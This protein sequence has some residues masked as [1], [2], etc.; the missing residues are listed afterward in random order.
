MKKFS[1]YHRNPPEDP[2]FEAMLAKLMENYGTPEGEEPS[3]PKP[4]PEPDPVAILTA[5]DQ[6]P[7]P[8][9]EASAEEVNRYFDN[10]NFLPPDLTGALQPLLDKLAATDNNSSRPRAVILN[11]WINL[12]SQERCDKY[13]PPLRRWRRF[14]QALKQSLKPETPTLT[15]PDLRELSPLHTE[16]LE[17]WLTTVGSLRRVITRINSWWGLK[18]N[19]STL[20]RYFHKHFHNTV[21]A[22]L[23]EALESA[24]GIL[25]SG[26]AST[27]LLETAIL[28]LDKTIY[29]MVLRQPED[30]TVIKPAVNLLWKLQQTL[31]LRQKPN[32]RAGKEVSPHRRAALQA[33]APQ[34]GT[35]Q[36]I[37]QTTSIDTPSHHAKC[38]L[39][40]ASPL[41][42]I[43]A[44][45]NRTAP[46]PPP[47]PQKP[48]QN[49]PVPCPSQNPVPPPTV[50]SAHPL[51]NPQPL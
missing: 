5:L 12:F 31:T 18:I 8:P 25:E 7:I 10:P 51:D 40:S 3:P 49:Q 6:R 46:V 43:P 13:E 50:L 39:D 42:A 23:P 2:R 41:S 15:A 4:P 33:A 45:Q 27:P 28:L 29:E 1:R 20:S 19:I 9:V 24:R 35:E 47:V 48:Q 26:K 14:D 16:M 11:D 21:T 34:P 17:D 32:P 38:P 44:P 22:E 36:E 30:I 37:S